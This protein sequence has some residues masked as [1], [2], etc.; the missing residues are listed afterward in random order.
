MKTLNSKEIQFAFG[1]GFLGQVLVAGTDQGVSSILIGED[2]HALLQELKERFP[3]AA[4]VEARAEFKTLTD[5]VLRFVESPRDFPDFPLDLGGTP[6]QRRVWDALLKI[7]AGST[8]TYAEIARRLGLSKGSARAVARA[9]ATNALAVVIPC[10]RAVGRDGRL[11]GYRWGL[12]RKR[13]L[14]EKELTLAKN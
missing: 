5:Q 9:C 10:H 8:A 11:T 14:L 7:P 6:F 3:K 4:L 1:E 2:R 13:R 12:E